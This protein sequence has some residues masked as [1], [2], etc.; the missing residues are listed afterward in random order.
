VKR[1]KIIK[2]RK[3]FHFFGYDTDF[4]DEE[5]TIRWFVIYFW[6]FSVYWER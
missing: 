2:L 6:F 5:R 3:P 4:A 1:F